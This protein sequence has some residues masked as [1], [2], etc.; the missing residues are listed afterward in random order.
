M[1]TDLIL[2]SRDGEIRLSDGMA[3][4][5]DLFHNFMFDAVYRNPSAKGEESKVL[6]ILRGIFD[7]YVKN[8][9]KLPP[10][11]LSI[12][13]ADGLERAVCDYVAC[14]TDD[15]ALTEYGSIFIPAAWTVK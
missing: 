1:I 13:H 6:G 12:A 7:Y 14:M 4:V 15:Y 11:F 9:D 5:F 10:E 8:P 3:E 2:S